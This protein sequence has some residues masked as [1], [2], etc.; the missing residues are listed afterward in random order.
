MTVYVRA[1]HMYIKAQS[2]LTA[3]I[4]AVV[5]YQTDCVPLV[6]E[7]GADSDSEDDV[8]DAVYQFQ[9]YVPSFILHR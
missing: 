3:L 4:W 2:G 8:R 1:R 5:Q 7:D 9:K 6:S